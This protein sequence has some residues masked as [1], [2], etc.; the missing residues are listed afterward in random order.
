MRIIDTHCHLT[1]TPLIEEI[2]G[3]LKEASTVGVTRVIVPGTTVETSRDAVALS[4][5]YP[6]VVYA[7]AGV[8]PG[9]A[10]EGDT[11]LEELIPGCVAVGEVGLDF[12]EGGVPGGQYPILDRQLLLAEKYGKPVIIHSRDCFSELHAVLAASWKQK[13]AVIHC[14]TGTRE[15][16]S[17]WLDLGYHISLTGIL[18]YKNAEGLRDVAKWLP[19]ERVM[20][21]TDAPWLAPVPHR[22]QSC[23]PSMVTEVVRT[24][25]GLWAMPYE[26]VAE[27][28]TKNAEAFFRL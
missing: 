24:L 8:H 11:G 7:A 15:E 9:H 22:G 28:T 13:P 21:E 12:S 16:A 23:R 27:R 1:Y 20:V 4:R 5:R 25:E 19:K 17:A 14:F 18:T 26:Q 3:V 6:G 10:G 2:D